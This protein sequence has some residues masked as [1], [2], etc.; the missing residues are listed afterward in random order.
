MPWG[1]W[2]RPSSPDRGGGW[3]GP[4]SYPKTARARENVRFCGRSKFMR[5]TP[6]H[7]KRSKTLKAPEILP[8][9]FGTFQGRGGGVV[10]TP[11]GEGWD[12]STTNLNPDGLPLHP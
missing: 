3:A 1:E 11:Q 10:W 6:K 8:F 9:L 2:V 5:K 12:P 7:P 4:S